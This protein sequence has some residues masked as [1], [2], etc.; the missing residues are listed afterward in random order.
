MQ[1]FTLE[2]STNVCIH[3][4]RSHA[5][6]PSDFLWARSMKSWWLDLW[7][8]TW[9]HAVIAKRYGVKC[10]SRVW[11][12]LPD[13]VHTCPC[14]IDPFWYASEWHADDGC[15]MTKNRYAMVCI[16]RELALAVEVTTSLPFCM[17]STKWLFQSPR[18]SVSLAWIDPTGW[19]GEA[20]S[21]VGETLS[22]PVAHKSYVSNS[23][24]GTYYANIMDHLRFR[25]M[26]CVACT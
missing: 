16:W 24:I 13:Y 18:L 15:A 10:W 11:S 19:Q 26:R 3:Y 22:K 8:P 4:T 12:T 1:I 17:S 6:L 21:T 25:T 5:S 23:W 9:W 14:Y 20:T 2:R 7:V